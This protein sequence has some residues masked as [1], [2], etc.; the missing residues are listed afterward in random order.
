M[1]NR[2]RRLQ[3][4]NPR[5]VYIR[6]PLSFTMI[7]TGLNKM[8]RNSK[9]PVLLVFLLVFN[10]GKARSRPLAKHDQP[11]ISAMKAR[12]SYGGLGEGDSTMLKVASWGRVTEANNESE[13]LRVSPGGPDP[14]HH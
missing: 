14:E 11:V 10:V 5:M 6:P 7:M 4:K 9:I 8:I 2:R 12:R 13:S 3:L 1:A